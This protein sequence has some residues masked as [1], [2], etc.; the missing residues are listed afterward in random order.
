MKFV[1][2]YLTLFFFC[3]CFYGR[4]D[5]R[6]DGLHLYY[7]VQI[8]FSGIY[9]FILGAQSCQL[10]P[11]TVSLDRRIQGVPPPIHLQIIVDRA[12]WVICIYDG[13]LA[14]WLTVLEIIFSPRPIWMITFLNSYIQK[15]DMKVRF[16]DVVSQSQKRKLK[17]LSP[18]RSWK[19]INLTSIRFWPLVLCC[20]WYELEDCKILLVANK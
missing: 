20:T 11:N 2:S 12:T 8:M 15:H 3:F 10:E 4:A 18:M 16:A 7:I 6:M 19:L 5:W 17:I 13:L 1:P 14:L 9:F